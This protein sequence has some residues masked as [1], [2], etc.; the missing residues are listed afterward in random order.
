M[1][2]SIPIGLCFQGAE[3][4]G[5]PIL[6]LCRLRGLQRRS[7]L[8]WLRRNHT[9]T[10]AQHRILTLVQQGFGKIK[11]QVRSCT[12]SRGN[13]AVITAHRRR[14]IASYAVLTR[15]KDLCAVVVLAVV[16]PKGH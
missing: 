15:P 2:T 3:L 6:L 12:V 11:G 7:L 13:L 8:S 10:T 4:S 14:A 1:L 9:C 16:A 5:R